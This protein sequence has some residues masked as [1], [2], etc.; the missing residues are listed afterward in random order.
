MQDTFHAIERICIDNIWA[1]TFYGSEWKT[2][3][4]RRRDFEIIMMRWCQQAG[5]RYR[6]INKENFMIFLKTQEDAL[7]V[8]LAF[9]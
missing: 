2:R 3:N 4:Q 8:Y 7:L 6:S 5:I 1:V 9:K